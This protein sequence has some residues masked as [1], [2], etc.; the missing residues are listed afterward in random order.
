MRISVPARLSTGSR[1]LDDLP[2]RVLA[3]DPAVG[4]LEEVAAADLDGL[5]RALG[6]ADRPLRYPAVTAGPVAVVAVVDVGDP[7]EPRLDPLPDLVG[8]DQP[9]PSRRRS[10]RHV[11]DAVLGEERQNP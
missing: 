11:E 5:S 7:V 3:A 6:A 1:L 9:A 8:A 4:E 2:E 10:A